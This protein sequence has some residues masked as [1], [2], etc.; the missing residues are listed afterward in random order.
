MHIHEIQW[1]KSLVLV[2]RRYWTD[3]NNFWCFVK[4]RPSSRRYADLEGLLVHF[5]PRTC[6]HTISVI[7]ENSLSHPHCEV[8][9]YVLC[10]LIDMVWVRGSKCTNRPSKSAYLRELGFSSQKHQK[11]FGKLHL[12]S[13]IHNF[14]H[15]WFPEKSWVNR[16]GGAILEKNR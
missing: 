15:K 2:L 9:I 8:N 11:L 5:D 13:E 12:S 16:S 7:A 6:T 3:F 4:L 14:K 1:Q 10:L